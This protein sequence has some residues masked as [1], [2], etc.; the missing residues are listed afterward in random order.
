MSDDQVVATMS[1]SDLAAAFA[2]RPGMFIGAPVRFDRVVAYIRGYAHAI[3]DVRAALV[4][5]HTG[6]HR[7]AGLESQCTDQLRAEGR[8]RWDRWDLTIVAEA[9]GWDG[10]Q[11]P[12]LEDLSEEQDR[13]AINHLRP[14]L[15]RVFTLPDE[16]GLAVRPDMPGAD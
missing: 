15:E 8:L 16:V 2:R 13:A 7:P 11:P 12:A 14:L 6:A 9:I 3:E 1:A 4:P 10:D 5:G